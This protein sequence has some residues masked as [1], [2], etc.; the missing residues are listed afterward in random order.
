MRSLQT[1]MPND[2]RLAWR[3]LSARPLS[4]LLI[5]LT[6][7]LGIGVSR[8]VYSALSGLL[9]RRQPLVQPDRMIHMTSASSDRI[10]V[11]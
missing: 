5:V 9:L 8:A 3:S 11:R 10:A 2:V 6:L 1:R 7:G 4:A